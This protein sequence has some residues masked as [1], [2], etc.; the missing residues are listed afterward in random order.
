MSENFQSANF[1][2]AGTP[3]DPDALPFYDKVMVDQSAAGQYYVRAWGT[4]TYQYYEGAL[5]CDEG[6]GIGNY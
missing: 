5:T 1:D 2:E 4:R 3:L 6:C